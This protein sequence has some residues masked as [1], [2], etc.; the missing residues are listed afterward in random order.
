MT[1]ILSPFFTF[2][3]PP[4]YLF[5]PKFSFGFTLNLFFNFPGIGLLLSP[6][7]RLPFPSN[8]FFNFPGNFLLSSSL[9]LPISPNLSSLNLPG[10]GLSSL[11][12]FLL[13]ISPNLSSLN[14]PG[15]GLSL[16]PFFLIAFLNP[17]LYLKSFISIFAIFASIAFTF[18]PTFPSP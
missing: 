16:R 17:L 1:G 12:S 9:L 4:P 8:G 7:P 18:W 11:S 2:F 15:I 3:L 10:N 14:F 6:N 5:I 13:G